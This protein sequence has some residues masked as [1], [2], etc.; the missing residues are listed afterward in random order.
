MPAVRPGACGGQD[1]NLVLKDGHGKPIWYGARSGLLRLK[2]LKLLALLS[3]RMSSRFDWLW[4]MRRYTGTYGHPDVN[5]TL[6]V[7]PN[8]P[9]FCVQRA[10]PPLQV[11][12]H[13]ATVNNMAPLYLAP[14]PHA[15]LY[16]LS[17]GQVLAQVRRRHENPPRGKPA[18][19]ASLVDTC[20]TLLTQ[21]LKVF[22]YPGGE[23]LYD[24][25][26]SLYLKVQ[27]DGNLVRA[28]PPLP[29]FLLV[30]AYRFSDQRAILGWQLPHKQHGE[31]QV[32]YNTSA[33]ALVGLQ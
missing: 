19:V 22:P 10:Y 18:H 3:L 1:G 27:G 13:C 20:Q 25:G 5:A 28:P 31:P 23:P 11:A 6:Y 2:K 8:G 29:P 26:G 14:V 30:P 12:Q 24:N 15:P 9:Y 16:G 7:S 32:Y 21:D 33:V 4:P 17:A